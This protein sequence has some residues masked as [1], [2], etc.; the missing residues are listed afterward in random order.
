MMMF[1]CSSPYTGVL[2]RA[3]QRFFGGGAGLTATGPDDK[4][5]L[6]TDEPQSENR[7]GTTPARSNA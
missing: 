1:G 6:P 5:P 3:W 7:A 2:H 4:L